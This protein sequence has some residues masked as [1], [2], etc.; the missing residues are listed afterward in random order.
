MSVNIG[1][2]TFMCIIR[3]ITSN[4]ISTEVDL[5]WMEN[6]E[7]YSV[8]WLSDVCPKAN[9]YLKRNY[10]ELFIRINSRVVWP[11]LP[12]D[13]VCADC[14]DHAN[15]EIPELVNAYSCCNPHCRIG[16]SVDRGKQF[17]NPFRMTWKRPVFI[18]RKCKLK[19]QDCNCVKIPC[20][21]CKQEAWNGDIYDLD[22]LQNIKG[23]LWNECNRCQQSRGRQRRGLINW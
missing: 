21:I 7:H 16:N 9:R 11:S 20:W 19:S 12:I 23:Y 8:T 17:Q 1:E 6:G 18:C 13:G 2:E 14:N 10:S 5:F 3:W 22:E 4:A 15:R